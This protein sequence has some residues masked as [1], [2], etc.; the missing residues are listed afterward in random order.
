MQVFVSMMRSREIALVDTVS[1]D[2]PNDAPKRNM[3]ACR[4]NWTTL[5]LTDLWLQKEEAKHYGSHF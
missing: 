3:G 1:T 4:K 2:M 5:Y